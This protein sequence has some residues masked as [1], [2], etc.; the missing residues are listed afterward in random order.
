M[1]EPAFGPVVRSIGRVASD[2]SSMTAVEVSRDRLD[3]DRS[4]SS[5]RS[6]PVARDGRRRE[7]PRSGSGLGNGNTVDDVCGSFGCGPSDPS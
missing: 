1:G 4:R 2:R 6:L 7:L 3:P 5:L